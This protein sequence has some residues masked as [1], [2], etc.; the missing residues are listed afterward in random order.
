[1]SIREAIATLLAG[2]DLSAEQA[3]TAM[4]D[5]MSGEATPAQI[6][7]Y[8]IALRMKGE[9]VQEIVGSARAMRDHAIR[10]HPRVNGAPLVDTCGTGGDGSGTFNVSTTVAFVVAATGRPVAKHGNRSI[11]SRSGSADVLA[12][13]GARIDLTPQEVQKAIEEVGIGFLFAP[14]FHP[15]MKYAIGPRRELRVRTIFNILGPLTNPAGATHQLM[16]VFD[17]RLTEPLAHVLHELGVRAAFVVHGH[18]GLDE[19][20]ITGSNRISALREGIV[21]TYELDPAELGFE[22]APHSALLGGTAEE[23]ARITRAILRGEEQGPKRDMVLLNAAAAIAT[24]TGD[25]QG[26]LEEARAALDSGKA[27]H[28]LEAFIAFTHRSKAV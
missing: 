22:R 1:M 18:G 10:I 16:G 7:A 15:A 21:D 9:T 13:L 2:A 25:W 26:A 5:I 14:N 4:Q 3:Y 28:T 23:N 24:E 27:F 19:L 6:G 17:P 12:A 11:S 8:L 20:S